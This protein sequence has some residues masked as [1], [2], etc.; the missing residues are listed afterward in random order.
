MCYNNFPQDGEVTKNLLL[1]EDEKKRRILKRLI[2]S[3]D[4][5]ARKRK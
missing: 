4:D 5:I 3:F 1:T 2:C